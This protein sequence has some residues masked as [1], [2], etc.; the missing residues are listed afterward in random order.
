M[1][2]VID[3]AVPKDLQKYLRKIFLDVN[4]PWFIVDEIS[5]VAGDAQ[6][7]GWAHV[8]RANEPV[9]PHNDLCLATLMIVA[10]KL[11]ISVNNVERIRAGLFTQRD[12]PRIHNPH[13]DYKFKHLVML[14][15][16]IDSDGPTFFYNENNEIIK[17]VEP[18]QG[19]AVVF[20]G[21]IKHA[22][23]S[24]ISSTKRLVINYNFNT[25]DSNPTNV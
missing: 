15:Y 9:S 18:K 21:L 19:R 8:I 17:T 6:T 2:E 13:I 14:Y 4:F 7:E 10:D 16:I 3:N 20:D 1:I 23:S 22:S 11:N 25:D 5:G 24:P 12:S